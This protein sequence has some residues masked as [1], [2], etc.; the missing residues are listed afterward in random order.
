MI[1]PFRRTFEVAA[2]QDHAFDTYTRDIDRWWPASHTHTGRSDLRIVFEGR[3]GGRIF[4]RTPEGEEHDWGRVRVWEPPARLVYS[5]HLRRDPAEW[6]EVEIV[7]R[8]ISDET[9]RVEIEHR[10]WERLGARGQ[11]ERDEHGSGWGTLLPHY[12]SAVEATAWK[13]EKA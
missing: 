5:W 9:T 4:E 12:Q 2:P 6:T 7:F 1:E 11:D 3:A 13:E 10:G 8:P